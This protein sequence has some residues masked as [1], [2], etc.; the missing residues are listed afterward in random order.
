MQQLIKD[1]LAYSRVK[2]RGEAFEPVQCETVVQHAIDNLKT[3][4]EESGVEIRLPE[5]SLPMVV[6]DN[7]QIT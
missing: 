1:L 5:N 2:T 6:G 3:A 4:I 7:T